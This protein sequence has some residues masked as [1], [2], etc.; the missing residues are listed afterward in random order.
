[1]INFWSFA[2]NNRLCQY[3]AS[4]SAM[5]ITICSGL[6][7]GWTSPY[8]PVLLDKNSPILMTNEESSWVAV[9]YLIAGPCGAIT[10]GLTLNIFGRKPI[11]ICSSI[12]FFVSWLMLAFV[13][14]L[15]EL[16]VLRFVAGFADGLIFG[17]TPIY[18]AEIVDKQIRGFFCSFISIVFIIGV[19]IINVLGTYLSIRDSSLISA[20][21]PIAFLLIFVWMPESPNYLLLKGDTESARKCL[22]KLRGSTEVD[23]E[24]EDIAKSVEEEAAVTFFHLFTSKT[25]RRSLLVVM[26]MRGGQQL[27]GFVAIIF[28]AQTVF[29]DATD[30]ISP[31]M[32]VVILYS[33]QITFSIASSLLVDKLGRRPLLITSIITTAIALLIEG[34]YFYLR[35]AKYIEMKEAQWVPVGSLILFMVAYSIG[36]QIIPL[37]IVGEIFPTNLRPHAAAFSDVYYF[38]F[39]FVASKFFQVTKDA[40]GM[41]VSFFTFSA[42]S[43]IGLVIIICFV[44]E[45]KNKT[46][47]EI[48][49]E[50]KSLNA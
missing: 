24:L 31:L 18:L 50:L 11:L 48:Q 14:T 26:G 45:T 9:I 16:L 12:T 44:P 7:F 37:F 40:F 6:H 38:L 43:V 27:S 33:V 22:E 2:T 5:L 15:T 13:G 30:I 49:L 17:T 34:T 29:Q 19:L 46:L 47:H 20:T 8:M 3:A 21:L 42:C 41:Y 28:Y 1:M 25:H 39:A 4:F 35:D 32:S 36:L 23:S 10:A